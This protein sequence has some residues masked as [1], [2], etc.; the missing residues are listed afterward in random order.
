VQGTDYPTDWQN[1]TKRGTV[2][3]KP[4]IG[5]DGKPMDDQGSTF[6]TT[7]FGSPDDLLMTPEDLA[8]QKQK[9]TD[10]EYADALNVNDIENARHEIELGEHLDAV[11]A[12][13]AENNQALHDYNEALNVYQ[14]NADNAAAAAAA[15]ANPS[16]TTITPE[17][18]PDTSNAAPYGTGVVG[19]DYNP[20]PY[21]GVH[22]DDAA[23]RYA[24]EMT[25]ANNS[26]GYDYGGDIGGGGKAFDYGDVN[27]SAFARGGIASLPKSPGQKLLAAHRAGDMATVH[28]MLRKVRR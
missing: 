17:V 15:A 11:N 18:S 27:M 14:I 24:Q 19:F 10:A 4:M 9:E 3:V 28:R 1:D 12:V 20:D 23:N 7:T 21:V 25:Q 8:A 26:G 2:E 13:D 22:Y 6:T 5:P 16:P